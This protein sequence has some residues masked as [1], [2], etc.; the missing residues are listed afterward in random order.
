MRL[1]AVQ[2]IEFAERGFRIS[3]HVLH[4]RNEELLVT[5]LGAGLG[6]VEHLVGWFSDAGEQD[7]GERIDVGERRELRCV[8]G[9]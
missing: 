4:D 2:A 8:D 5:P 9:A 7:L 6:L 3:G 1:L